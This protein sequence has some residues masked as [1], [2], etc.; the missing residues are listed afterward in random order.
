MN[1][2]LLTL[3]R[4][5]KIFAS[6][7]KRALKK[8]LPQF[9]KIELHPDEILYDQGDPSDSISILLEGKLA[10]I[11]TTAKGENKIVGYIEPGET[12]G[13][14]G[15]ISG[16]HRSTT[17]KAIKNS[18]LFKLP[19]EIFV[20][21]CHE[22][23][24]VLF[25]IINPI[26]SRS[27]EIIQIVSTEKSKKHIVIAPANNE[28]SLGEF[29]KNFREIVDGL[30]SVVVLSDYDPEL[31]QA[32]SENLQ[33]LLDDAKSKNVKKLK[34][35]IL[36]IIKNPETALAKFAFDKMEMLYIVANDISPILLNARITEKIDELA[37]KNTKPELILMH[38]KNLHPPFNTK[39]WLHL[40]NF[41]LHYHIKM[42]QIKDY[43][44]LLRFIR[45]KA[46]GLTLSGGGTRGWAH[47]GAI[48][49]ILEAGIPID[50]V[51][52]CSVG[53]IVAASY[54]ITETYEGTR[55]HFKEIIEG[56]RYSV[57]WRNLTWPAIS[58]FNA[59]GLT[60][61]LQKVYQDIRIEDLWLPFFCVSTNLANDSESIHTEGLLWERLRCSVS[62]P[63]LI[64]PM[65]LNGELHIDGGLLNNLPV[66][67]MRNFIGQRSNVIAVEIAGYSKDG[68][69]Y[70]FPPILSFWQAFLS[71]LGIAYEYK[72]PPFIDTF[73]KSLIV[74]SSLKTNLNSIEANIF[75]NLDLSQFPMLYSNKRQVHQ[76]I[77]I[78]YETTLQQIKNMKSKT[79]AI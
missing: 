18:T 53:G 68:K 79:K 70:D 55:A 11:L 10:S 40:A 19:S 29:S 38:D 50:A 77:N 71:K 58:L 49:A 64:P 31:E 65:V 72:F 12:A 54:A 28:V 76:I 62:I 45:G 20:E 21:L 51:G 34:Q 2:D 46:V 32:S 25:E 8:I 60:S 78:G 30:I 7:N 61:V 24:T 23:P 4:T 75:V 44:R 13:E 5:C 16:E 27:Q 41:G 39:K 67:I 52:G 22:Y 56:S 26:V 66:D 69:K 9:E 59:R 6:L 48:K 14:I 42:N 74:G 17:I 73:L 47:I 37:T 33:K 36:Y 63:G 35:K 57:S 43:H 3:L 1:D 15:A